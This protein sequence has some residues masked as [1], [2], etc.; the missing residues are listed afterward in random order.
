MAI[1][2]NFRTLTADN[3][4]GVVAPRNY[5]K[6]SFENGTT[7]G[8]TEMAVTLTSGL[9][10]GTPTISS[11]AASSI[12]LSNTTITPL[13]L[14]RSL[15]VTGVSG[16]TAGQGFISDEF[17]IDRMDAGKPLTVSFDY[18]R[19]SGTLNFSGTLGSQT[20]MV[21]IYDA[22][23]GGA[24]W[25]QPAGYLGMNQSSGP[26]RVT[27]TFQSSVVAGQKYRVAVIASQAV[28]SACSLEF[29]NFTCS[30]VTAPIGPVAIDWELLPQTI[31]I[32]GSISNPVKGT[33][34]TDRIYRRR[35]GDSASLRYNYRQSA[36]SANGGSGNYLFSLPSGMSFDAS[37]VNITGNLDNVVGTFS[38]RYGGGI[39]QYA[40]YCIAVSS[41][42]F[43]AYLQFQREGGTQNAGILGSGLGNLGSVGDMIFLM[44]ITAPIS[45]WSSSVQMSNDTD[46][47]VVAAKISMG[48][49]GGTITLPAQNTPYYWIFDPSSSVTKDTHG[50][51]VFVGAGPNVTTTY[52]NASYYQIPVSG[53]YKINASTAYANSGVTGFKRTVIYV[54]GSVAVENVSVS[55]LEFTSAVQNI[56]FFNAG[57]IIKIGSIFT[58]GS[59]QAITIGSTAPTFA[60]IERLSGPSVV[61]ASETVAAEYGSVAGNSFTPITWTFLDF[62]SKSGDTHGA[63]LGAGNGNSTNYTNTWRFIA[64]VSGR[65]QVSA[66]LGIANGATTTGMAL[67]NAIYINGAVNKYGNRIELPTTASS[68]VYNV[69]VSGE[70]RVNAGDAVSIAGFYTGLVRNAEATS[71]SNWV[72]IVRVGN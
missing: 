14:S 47:R 35:V 25:I 40:G 21:Y 53:W 10:T 50:A 56:N 58:G 33:V 29:D 67:I 70:V 46:T 3:I 61:A 45:G 26:G 71:I 55:T 72:S 20:L 44:D 43:I 4:E 1:N 52:A 12:A 34:V 19:V 38:G 48:T 41:T 16:W 8:W 59:N 6:N 27:A 30:R 7:A 69:L 64:P 51:I 66:C 39:D 2:S 22:T 65:Y 32:S 23:A 18:E 42:Q 57:D 17:T 28:G 24:N 15:L 9:P 5:L 37:K 68:A 54:N 11:T 60:M 63:V 49:T 13:S 62:A 31:T 36:A